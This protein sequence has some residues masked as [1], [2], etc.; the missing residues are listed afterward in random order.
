MRHQRLMIER[1]KKVN[2]PQLKLTGP[3]KRF[4]DDTTNGSPESASR[5][6]PHILLKGVKG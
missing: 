2:G 1:V 6:S 5:P 4:D 3:T